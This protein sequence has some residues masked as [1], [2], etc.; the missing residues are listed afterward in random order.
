MVAE[1]VNT[2]VDGKSYC[3][4]SSYYKASANP[5]SNFG[6]EIRRPRVAEPVGLAQRGRYGENGIEQ[7]Y[8]VREDGKSNCLTTVQKD[9]LVGEP[10]NSS[11]Q[12]GALPRPNGELSKSQAFRI[13]DTNA[14][15]VTL[16]SGGCGAGGKTGLHAIPVFKELTEKEMDYMVRGHADRR[17]NAL[18]KPGEKD[19]SPTITANIH[20]GVPYNVCAIPIEWIEGEPTQ[21]VS[22]SDGKAHKVYKVENGMICYKDKTYPIKLADGYYIIRK[23]TVSEC[24]RLQTVPEWYKFPVSDTQGYKMLGNGWSVDVIVHLIQSIMR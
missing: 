12:V 20:R 17:W 1:P 4:T 6:E 10:V 5:F 21:A 19:K 18:V 22:T 14:K 9:T 3:L 8:E 11:V 23:L 15:S 13:Y 16:K 2:T 24:K 7:H